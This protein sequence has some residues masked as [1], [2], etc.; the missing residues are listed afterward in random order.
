MLASGYVVGAN[1]GVV[2][3]RGEYPE[4][5]EKVQEVID[6]LV[7]DGL[8]GENI[9]GSGFDFTF[10]IVA[11]QGAYIC[12]EETALLNSVEGQRPEVR[13]RPPYPAQRGLFTSCTF[14][15]LSGYS[16]RI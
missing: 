12:G 15:I 16:P 1:K 9:F 5:I 6:S 3:I 2:Y 11:G 7:S 13:V 4:S 10:K 8:A 14:S